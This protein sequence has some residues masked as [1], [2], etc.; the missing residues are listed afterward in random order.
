MVLD[1]IAKQFLTKTPFA[2]LSRVLFERALPDSL[3]DELFE[4]HSSL[5]YT[6]ELLFSSV[7]DLLSDVVC[8]GARSVGSAYAQRERTAP[9]PVSVT[10]V[11]NKLNHIEPAVSAALVSTSARQLAPLIQLLREQEPLIPG[12]RCKIVDGNH[13]SATERRLKVHRG[14]KPPPL[15]AQVLALYDPQAD[16]VTDIVPCEDAHAQERRMTEELLALIRP[17]ECVIADRNFCTMRILFGLQEKAAFFIVRQ[18]GLTLR[19]EL[20]GERQ[21]LGECETGRLFEQAMVLE[22]KDG[23][24]MRI[25]RITIELFKPT[26]DGHNEIHILTNLP[27]AIADARTIA[28][29]YRKRWQLEHVFLDL[30][31]ALQCEIKTLGYPRAALLGFAVAVMTYNVLSGLRAAVRAEHGEEEA[32]QL[33]LYYVTEEQ[34]LTMKGMA[35]ILPPKK[36]KWCRTC[37]AEELVEVLRVGVR[38]AKMETYRKHVRGP[39]KRSPK[40]NPYGTQLH[41]STAQLLAK[42]RNNSP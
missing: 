22:S 2:F 1:H 15:P 11:Y 12:V 10:S 40:R 14:I 17:G 3:I 18:H 9:V 35:L 13:F 25:R 28:Q 4:Q 42:A 6:R 31:V 21:S 8:R 24:V 36:W 39:K 7:V 23:S 5:Q 34:K 19:W 30:T 20:E 27:N 26:R 16:L 33:S 38:A 32:E 37:T 41:V 29:V